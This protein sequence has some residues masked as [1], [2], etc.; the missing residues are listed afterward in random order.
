MF[1]CDSGIVFSKRKGNSGKNNVLNLKVGTSV[2]YGEN[3]N[4]VTVDVA[5]WGKLGDALEDIV[6]PYDKENKD[7]PYSKVY[8]AGQVNKMEIN[9]KGY[10]TVQV[11]ANDIQVFTEGGKADTHVSSKKSTESKEE[12]TTKGTDLF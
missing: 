2:G 10:L 1:M 11:N 4:N 8:F 5:I 7:K 6:V 12:K 9:D 3:K